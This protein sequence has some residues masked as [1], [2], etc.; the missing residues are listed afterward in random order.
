MLLLVQ[1]WGKVI[2]LLPQ[3]PGPLLEILNILLFSLMTLHYNILYQISSFEAEDIR[4]YR[5][6]KTV[7]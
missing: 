2:R 5:T 6:Y 4:R 7:L 3:K 1:N